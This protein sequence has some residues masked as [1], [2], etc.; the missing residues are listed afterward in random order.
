[1]GLL[2]PRGRLEIDHGDKDP[3]HAILDKVGDLSDFMLLWNQI[4]V[5]IYEMPQ[6]AKTKG[7]L[8]IPDKTKQENLFQGK[9]GLVVKRGP[10]AYKDS[11]DF[12]FDG[13]KVEVGDWVLVRPQEGW[14][15]E[16]NGA[17]MRIFRDTQIIAKIPHP[18]Y[19]F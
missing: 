5:A 6:N 17:P 19:V 18:D 8:Y 7:G 2:L 12:K 13:Q 10:Q 11:D 3:R 15:T 4:A 9:A 16:I 1:M 14:M